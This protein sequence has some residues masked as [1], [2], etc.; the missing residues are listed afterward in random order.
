MTYEAL[1]TYW[2]DRRLR[3]LELVVQSAAVSSLVI[4]FT[5]PFDLVRK[6]MQVLPVCTCVYSEPIF[7]FFWF[8]LKACH[9]SGFF[10]LEN[11]FNHVVIKIGHLTIVK[12]RPRSTSINSG[13]FIFI[14]GKI[15]FKFMYVRFGRVFF[16]R[17]KAAVFLATVGKGL[18]SPMPEPASSTRY[19][20]PVY[21]DFGK[22]FSPL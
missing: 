8:I 14:K 2:W 21:V 9:F 17:Q 15:M 22:D 20:A 7:I 10:T 3:P 12:R 16:F 4:T 18:I 19:R 5:F 11:L 1:D 6:R 13:F